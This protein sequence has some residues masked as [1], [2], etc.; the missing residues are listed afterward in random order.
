MGYCLRKMKGRDESRTLF[1][2]GAETLA[3][4]TK[5]K[6]LVIGMR[7][8]GF[9]VAKNLV[10][11][12]PNQVSIYDPGLVDIAD[13]GSNFYLNESQVGKV[14]RA[15]A[16]VGQLKELNPY[17]TVDVVKTEIKEDILKQ[18]TVVVVTEMLY[19]PSKLMEMN[20]FCRSQNPPIAFIMTFCMGLY[21]FTFTDF[22][23]KF[24]VKDKTGEPTASYVL[25]FVT[26]DNPGIVRVHEE[27]KHNL[28]DGDYVKFRDVEG[29]T[30]LNSADP[31]Q[32]EVIDKHS[33]KIGDTSKFS[34]YTKGG[35]VENIK[36]PSEVHFKSLKE[37]IENPLMSK[38]DELIN[39]DLRLF[40]RSNQLHLG[41]SALFEYYEKNKRLPALNN[42]E[43]AKEVV[44][45]A[46]VQ[47]ENR[48]KASQFF[49]ESLE[50]EVIKNMALFA[51]A[52]ITSVTSFFG[53]VA[54][55]EAFKVVGKYNPIQQWLHYDCFE[56][57]PDKAANRKL[58]GGR[59]DDIIAIYGQEIQE[60]IQDLN[61]LMIG[62]GALGC[63]F[64]KAFSMIGACTKKGLLTVTDNDHIELSNLN[65]QFLFKQKDI[66]SPKAEV[67]ANVGIKFNPAF[68]V[69]AMKEYVA[70]SS[71]HI[72]TDA[73]WNGY[74]AVI[75]A[76]DNI[77]AR[78]YVDSKCVWHLKPF[79][80]SGTL[81]TKANTQVIYPHLT[82]SYSDTVDPQEDHYPMCTIRNFPNLIEHT[83][84]WGRN[85][86]EGLFSDNPKNAAEFIKDPSAFMKQISASTTISGTIDILKGILDVVKLSKR[87]ILM[88]ASNM[89]EKNSKN[90]SALLWPNYSILSQQITKMKAEF[91]S[92]VDQRRL[93]RQSL[94]IPRMNYIYFLSN[95]RPM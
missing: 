81:G 67:A 65:R 34:E 91:L 58:L 73:V 74:D 17:I 8:I 88:L 1:T 13:I 19:P 76:V 42:E 62:A 87:T 3:K 61:M 22:G 79:L 45:I 30:E 29:M 21:G 93:Q 56:S 40:G 38:T 71:E 95:L 84:E 12:G 78:M 36:M 4:I 53:G 44:E 52:Q 82:Q 68:K 77:K 47:N 80:D 72:F 70:P 33:F 11:T 9:E 5:M 51:K 86:F 89:G 66:G 25:F 60:K 59:Y 83:I 14:S 37:S 28:N 90:T 27:K 43:D 32:V 31:M 26:K 16:C 39:A 41:L 24:L 85:Q 48:K 63:E 7:G 94:S 23:P 18:F 49:V 46:K 6:V 64:I 57:L 75:G 54:A 35:V 50:E 55:Q 69:K 2:Y 10:L 92:G 15:D 20:E